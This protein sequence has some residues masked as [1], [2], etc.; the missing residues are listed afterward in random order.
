MENIKNENEKLR[1]GE[2]V[3]ISNI[4][5]HAK[6]AQK[7][8]E[9]MQ[10]VENVTEKQLSSFMNH[11]NQHL[12]ALCKGRGLAVKTVDKLKKCKEMER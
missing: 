5:D 2:K 3:G 8:L 4:D 1:K 6:H 11:V 9:D 10:T 7:H 12:M